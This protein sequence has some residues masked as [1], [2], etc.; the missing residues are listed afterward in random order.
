ME[1]G[2]PAGECTHSSVDFDTIVN[3]SGLIILTSSSAFMICAAVRRRGQGDRRACAGTG[4]RGGLA[5]VR[6]LHSR[7]DNGAGVQE[8][9]AM[10]GLQK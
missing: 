9:L 4:V 5:V 2:G 6:V 10:S 3:A 1:G 7:C 8:L